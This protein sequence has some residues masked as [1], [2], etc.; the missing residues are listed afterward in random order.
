[1]SEK[2]GLTPYEGIE[3]RIL[4]LRGRRVMMDEDLAGLYG[5]STK[6]LNEQVKRNRAR[7]PEDFMFQ[8]TPQETSTMRSQIATASRRTLGHCPYVFTEHGAIMA[9]SVLSSDRAIEASVWVVRAFVKL[10]EAFAAHRLLYKKLTELEARVSSHDEELQAIVAALK[11]LMMEP[12]RKRRSIG[13]GVRDARA[14]YG[15]EESAV[16]P[17]RQRRTM[18]SRSKR[19]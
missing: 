3:R 9:A 11:A 7:F 16:S 8:L 14:R 13:F 6:R 1:M 4:F 10:R 17:R 19:K 12:P 2:T 15:N 18:A 5:V